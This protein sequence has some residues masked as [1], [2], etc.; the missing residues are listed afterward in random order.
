VNADGTVMCEDKFLDADRLDGL[1]TSAFQ[2]R[3]GD[4]CATG[5]AMRAVYA[6]GAVSCESVIYSAGSGLSL[7][8]NTFAINTCAD[9]QIMKRAGGA[10]ACGFDQSNS[11]SAGS[12]LDL[13]GS[14]FSVNATTIQGRVKDACSTGSSIRSIDQVGAVVCEADDDTIYSAGKGLSLTGTTF[15]VDTST[16]QQRVTDS[17]AS[18]Q[19]VRLIDED[20]TVLCEGKMLDADHLDGLDSAAFALTEHNHSDLYYTK[21]SSDERTGGWRLVHRSEFADD[22]EGFG[23]SASATSCGVHRVLG[24]FNG[25]IPPN[26]IASRDYDLTGIT[27]TRVM[28]KFDY[29]FGDSWDGE[30]GYAKLGDIRVWAKKHH[31]GQDNVGASNVCGL[32][33]ISLCGAVCARDVVESATGTI[34]HNGNTITVAF[35]SSLDEPTSNEWFGVSNVEIWVR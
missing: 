1:D 6:D 11:Y 35:G 13:T 22:H 7:I 8:G 27:H 32:T 10:W 25:A 15:S 5:Q 18:G 2:L 21:A 29:W 14:I 12:G 26:A 28:V 3:I 20:G 31:S 23:P 33:E 17:C 19:A 24:G 30:F 9:G 16:V 34:T 4:S